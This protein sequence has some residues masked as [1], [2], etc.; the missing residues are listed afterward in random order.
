LK[1]NRTFL[2]EGEKEK[3]RGIQR[4]DSRLEI[5]VER[6]QTLTPTPESSEE[7]GKGDD[8]EGCVKNGTRGI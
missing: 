1:P 6:G 2:A 8:E 5:A 4:G 3:H 7:K